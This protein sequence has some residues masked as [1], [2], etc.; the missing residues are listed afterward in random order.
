MIGQSGKTFELVRLTDFITLKV[1]IRDTRRNGCCTS[2]RAVVFT[3]KESNFESSHR[4]FL[5][6]CFIIIAQRRKKQRK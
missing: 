4:Q 3:T 6:N 2:G 1:S 5:N